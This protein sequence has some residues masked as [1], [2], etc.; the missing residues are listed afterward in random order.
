M[1][2]KLQKHILLISV[3]VS[4]GLIISLT[5]QSASTSYGDNTIAS[6]GRVLVVLHHEPDLRQIETI[7][8]TEHIK[9]DHKFLPGALIVSMTDV[10]SL[11]VLLAGYNVSLFSQAVSPEMS[12]NWSASAK[13][14]ALVWNTLQFP[15]EN[16]AAR[17]HSLEGDDFHLNHVDSFEAPPPVDSE[18]LNNLD[19]TPSFVESSQFLMGSVAV[20]IVLPESNGQVDPST[21]DWT[22]DERNQVVSEIAAGL[23]WWVTMDNR[24]NLS[25]VYDNLTANTVPTGYEPISR[26]HSDQRYWIEDA[27]DAMGYGGSNY[28]DQ[29]RNYNHYLRE[30]HN[31][32]WAFTIFVVDSTADSDNS[33]ENHYFAYAYLGGP[34][35]VMTYNNQNYGIN[36]MDAV[37]AHEMGHI[38]RA[39]DQYGSANQSC[40]KK[41]G[42]LAIENQNS[43]AGSDCMSDASSIMRGQVWPFV[44]REIDPFAQGQVGWWD[45]DK[46]GIFDVVDVDLHVSNV[47]TTPQNQANILTVTA[48]LEE[49]PYES[50]SYRSIIINKLRTVEYRIND[51]P[52]LTATA[53]D[54]NFDSYKEAITFTTEPL[55]DGIHTIHIRATDNMGKVNQQIIATP[56]VTDPMANSLN[57]SLNS[58]SALAETIEPNTTITI[59]GLATQTANGQVSTVEYRLENGNWQAATATDG[60]F[61][62]GN[63]AFTVTLDT[64]ALSP[65]TYTVFVRAIDN[66]GY[67]ESTPATETF[68]IAL[69]L[70]NIVYL[71]MLMSK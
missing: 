34:F 21:E 43:Q 19:P 16:L 14:A 63:E 5:P 27:M 12:Q 30:T 41:A 59:S 69:N 49:I 37:T 39:L 13:Q 48:N 28:F 10:A 71:P 15:T 40:Y 67:I 20:G 65:G 25:F 42:Y 29:V 9:V 6:H 26:V 55:T 51:G 52:W 11:T 46:N 8:Q 50:P 38:F 32:D 3:S 18:R 23:D 4:L 62:S 47:T 58:I 1:F 68:T 2:V 35:M 57:T 54:G 56:Q 22:A 45:A 33:F 7:F 64:T 61:D 31:T 60:S 70:A 36:N 24:A 66:Q 17:F 44:G 53:T